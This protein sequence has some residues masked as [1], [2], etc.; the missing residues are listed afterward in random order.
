MCD[1]REKAGFSGRFFNTTYR[2]HINKGA[3]L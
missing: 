2:N 1:T 3:L